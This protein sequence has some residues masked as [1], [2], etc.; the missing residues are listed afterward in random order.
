VTPA[1]VRD[2][3]PAA[4]E[5]VLQRRGPAVLAYCELACRP[6][7]AATVSAEAFAGFRAEVARAERPEAVDPEALLLSQTRRAAA[8][9]A[10]HSEPRRG[11]LARRTPG[12]NACELMPELLVARTDGTL[13]EADRDRLA[14]HLERCEACQAI[15]RRFH[16]AERAYGD[17]PPEPISG[18]V[19]GRLLSALASAAPVS[20]EFA[21]ANGSPAAPQAKPGTH[22][23]PPDHIPA[24]D[25]RIATGDPEVQGDAKPGN[26]D[27]ESPVVIPPLSAP[28]ESTS[29]AGILG[30]LRRG[31]ALPRARRADP[32]G[33]ADG[34]RAGGAWAWRIALP[35][36]LLVAAVAGALAVA[37][38][39]GSGS[40]AGSRRSIAHT[41]PPPVTQAAPT[42]AAPP[43]PA[44]ASHTPRHR[45]A[46]HRARHARH[47]TAGSGAGATS[48]TSGGAGGSSVSSG[49]GSSSGGDSSDGGGSSGGGSAPSSAHEGGS[50]GSAPP[51]SQAPPSSSPGFQ[52][53]P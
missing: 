47:T 53:S 22:E 39:F 35:A 38:I 25:P 14:R 15:A 29:G 1:G 49:G 46:A 8:R 51:A 26:D 23:P 33:R 28:T 9:H 48:G 42:P 4:L 12:R 30:P 40:R 50:A 3:D 44:R 19:F 41:P 17:P 36:A 18:E 16:A 37:G 10:P 7:A 20:P 34:Q 45:R 43:L 27:P 6:Q 11:L 2:G 13:S 5:G 31:R 21:E 52:P 32:L 24:A